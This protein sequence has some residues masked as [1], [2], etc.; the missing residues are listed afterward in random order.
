MDE[1]QDVRDPRRGTWKPGQSGNP[2]GKPPGTRNRA[3]Q[4]VLALMEG[5]AEEIT[6]AIC[7]HPTGMSSKTLRETAWAAV[8][9]RL[10]A[11][12]P[13]GDAWA[14]VGRPTYAGVQS[15]AIRTCL[16]RSSS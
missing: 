11:S 3:T 2:A 13:A 8:V 1:E 12:R 14:P 15:V 7:A 16:R 9:S 4:M 6:I 5:G 10:P